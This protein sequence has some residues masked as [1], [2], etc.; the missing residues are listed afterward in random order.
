MSATDRATKDTA[1][2]RV[3]ALRPQVLPRARPIGTHQVAFLREL[4]EGL[5]ARKASR[6]LFSAETVDAP[7]V[8][9]EVALLRETLARA[10]AASGKHH[11]LTAIPFGQLQDRLRQ[12]RKANA[13]A[14]R[15]RPDQAQ[16][17]QKKSEIYG[18]SVVDGFTDAEIEELASLEL[19]GAGKGVRARA[20]PL[21]PPSWNIANARTALDLLRPLVITPP[22]AAHD[23]EV[24]FRGK[25]F[26]ALRQAGV[27]TVADLTTLILRRGHRWYRVTPGIGPERAA[28]VAAWLGEE[29]GLWGGAAAMGPA[30]LKAP[31]KLAPGELALARR[32]S[33][34]IVPFETLVLPPHLDG[35]SGTHRVHD[36]CLLEERT[37]HGAIERWVKATCN[38]THTARAYA[39]EAE[40]LMLWCVLEK[41]VAMSSM[42]VEHCTEYRQFLLSLGDTAQPWPWRRPRSDWIAPRVSL[43]RTHPLWK[44]FAPMR[45]SPV[46]AQRAGMSPANVQRALVIVRSLF[47]WLV[48]GALYLSANPWRAVDIR[49]AGEKRAVGDTAHHRVLSRSLGVEELGYVNATLDSMGRDERGLRARAIIRTGLFTG[50]RRDELARARLGHLT[51]VALK[52][53]INRHVIKVVGKGGKTRT[54]VLPE[55]AERVMAEYLQAR[56]IAWPPPMELADQPLIAAVKRRDEEA[57]QGEYKSGQALTGDRLYTIAKWVFRN[58]AKRAEDEGQLV[59]KARLKEAGTH[60][61]RHTFGT[62]L[63]TGGVDVR[64]IMLQMGHSK[65]E[66]TLAYMSPDHE[67][68]FAQVDKVFSS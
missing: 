38:N 39:R 45:T 25:T 66:T 14:N 21:P 23:I 18:R 54:V 58:A 57:Q 16:L 48:N 64:T 50:M 55:Q 15:L 4:I 62:T 60:W 30:A 5:P 67:A 34:A 27:R 13:E 8:D 35:S 29:Q 10:A 1:R 63:G 12:E 32:E 37:D 52:S 24:W 17:A 53:G 33:N 42:S 43:P 51:T 19:L 7:S 56:R 49:V 26:H 28:C 3:V 68:R 44:P 2:G 36:G 65:I 9:A 20:E 59:V 46:N 22:A 11:L 47:D 6:H 41:G 31:N 61:L 40:R